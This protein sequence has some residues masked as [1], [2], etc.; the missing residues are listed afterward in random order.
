MIVA[1]HSWLQ[2]RHRYS[3]RLNNK[4]LL[5]TWCCKEHEDTPSLLSRPLAP[6]SALLGYYLTD[7]G[8]LQYAYYDVW[9][10][11]DQVPPFIIDRAEA[12][13]DYHRG[14]CSVDT[15]LRT[16]A[17]CIPDALDVLGSRG[18]PCLV[19]VC[20]CSARAVCL[21]GMGRERVPPVA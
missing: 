1:R 20:E 4:R 3:A 17:A 5:G 7:A 8:D 9:R 6:V 18:E 10:V 16:T 14:C 11:F 12:W 2:A 13:P 19:A 21:Y 15:I